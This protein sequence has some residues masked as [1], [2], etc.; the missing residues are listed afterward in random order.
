[1]FTRAELKEMA[2]SQLK[3]RV[4]ILFGCNLIVGLLSSAMGIIPFLGWIAIIFISPVLQYGLSKLYLDVTKGEEPSI[5]AVFQGF[6]NFW[7]VFATQFVAGLLAFL[8]SFLFIIPGIIKGIAYSQV[9]YIRAE[10]PD[11]DIMEAIKESERIMNGHKMEY[12]ILGLS[13]IL[14]TLLMSITCGLAGIYVIPYMGL[15]MTN[16]Y[17]KIKQPVV[18]DKQPMDNY[19]SN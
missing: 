8:W 11:M 10:N 16:F 9:N 1:M 17:N 13:F 4:W 3:G 2:K 15:T 18:M 12:F 6:S 19:Y 7:K 5:D 14:W